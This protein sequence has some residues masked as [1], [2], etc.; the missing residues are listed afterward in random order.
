VTVS[1]TWPAT[2]YWLLASQGDPEKKKGGAMAALSSCCFGV[3]V[4][5]AA[6]TASLG[7]PFR[8]SRSDRST[9]VAISRRRLNLSH[10]A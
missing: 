6:L 1:R 2:G 9:A 5:A 3:S 4:Y 7:S 8:V 10:R